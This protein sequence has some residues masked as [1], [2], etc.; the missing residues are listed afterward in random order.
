MATCYIPPIV[1]KI[2]EYIKNCATFLLKKDSNCNSAFEAISHID[3]RL[4]NFSSEDLKGKW[5][6]LAQTPIFKKLI[7][8]RTLLTTATEN[9]DLFGTGNPK[10]VRDYIFLNVDFV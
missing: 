8:E 10:D 7:L 3:W 9:K 5:F 4:F 2:Q 1:S 6:I